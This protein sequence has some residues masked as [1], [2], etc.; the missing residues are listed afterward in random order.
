M[1]VTACKMHLLPSSAC[2]V[3]ISAAVTDDMLDDRRGLLNQCIQIFQEIQITLGPLLRDAKV[4]I[5][6]VV[7]WVAL[8]KN[9]NDVLQEPM[10]S[11]KLSPNLAC[12]F[13][14]MCVSSPASLIT[15][16]LMRD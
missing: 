9:D 13:L 16:G 14:S 11:Y 10:G 4:T 5:W 7:K 3:E 15:C 6:K 1:M 12:S 2:W 8:K